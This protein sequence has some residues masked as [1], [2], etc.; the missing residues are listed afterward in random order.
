MGGIM[1]IFLLTAI[2]FLQ[3]VILVFLV[4]FGLNLLKLISTLDQFLDLFKLPQVKES[5]LKDP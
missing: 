1:E 3:V 2:C 5:G 4:I